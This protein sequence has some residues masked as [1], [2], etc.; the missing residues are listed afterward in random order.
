MTPSDLVPSFSTK[1]APS[2]V[3]SYLAR[4]AEAPQAA[5]ARTQ[6]ATLSMAE[7]DRA[8]SSVAAAISGVT[9][10]S[11]ND[12]VVGVFAYPGF[13]LLA[14]IWGALLSG[15]AYCPLSPDY[16]D[17]RL[18]DMIVQCNMSAIVC[19]SGLETKLREVAGTQVVI[20]TPDFQNET[21]IGRVWH[22]P[23]RPG[24]LAYVIFT[25]GSTGRPK[26]VMIEHRNIAQ[27]MSWFHESYDLGPGT[28]ILQKTPFSFDAA[29][30][31]LLSSAF[32]ATLIFGSQEGYRNPFEQVRLI[33]QFGVTMLQCVPT[34]WRALLETEQLETCTSLTRIFSGGEALP[35]ELAK[36]CLTA[37]PG[38]VLVNLYGPTECTINASAFAV[39]RE[40]LATE[41]QTVPIGTPVAGTAFT[42]LDETGAEV[43]G[44]AIGE[45]HIAGIQ[46][47]RGYLGHPSATEKSF[48]PHPAAPQH[49]SYRTGD[50]AKYN[51]DGSVQ[52][53]SRVDGQ[54][55]IRGYRIELDEIR[56]AIENHEWVK[57][58]AVFVE[59]A[60]TTGADVLVGCVELSPNQAQLMDAGAAREHHRSK[61][62][63]LQVK[64]QIAGLGVSTPEELADKI[65]LDLPGRHPT[66]H[67][68]DRAF[69]RKS[70]RHFEGSDPI[71]PDEMT[72]VL[73]SALSPRQ[74]Q[75]RPRQGLA[76]VGT[77]LRNF[78]QFS[79]PERLLP[80]Y[81]YASPGALYATQ[82]YLLA[83]SHVALAD[84]VY[85]YHPA[86]HVLYRMAPP[87]RGASPGLELQFVGKTR[88]IADV[89]K[90]NIR[91]VLDF[92]VGHILGVFDEVLPEFG[93]AIGAPSHIA[94]FLSDVGA[95]PDDHYLG[96][97]RLTTDD[98][99]VWQGPA[100]T[101]YVQ[102]I[103]NGVSGLKTGL[104]ALRDDGLS[105]LGPKSIERNH[106]IAINQQVFERSQVGVGLCTH[107]LE[108]PLA[109]VALGRA[110]QRLQMNDRR[111]GFMPSGYNSTTGH[112]LRAA[113]R[114]Y[115]LIGER[116]GAFYFC[117]GGRVS[118]AQVAHRGMKEDSV[119]S[120]GPLELIKEELRARLPDY[121]VPRHLFLVDEIPTSANGKLDKRAARA[122]IDLSSLNGEA[123][124][125]APQNGIEAEI[126]RRWA[127]IIG[128]DRICT[129]Q[130]FFDAG[131]DSLGAVK[132]VMAINEA[133]DV[134]LPLE[135]IFEAA[136]IEALAKLIKAEETVA[137]T[138]LVDLA[139]AVSARSSQ[140]PIP[141]SDL[142][143]FC[144]PGLGGYPMSLRSLA[145]ELAPTG[146]PVVGVRLMASTRMK[147][148]TLTS[149]Q[150]PNATSLPCGCANPRAPTRWS[151]IPSARG[152]PSRSPASW[153]PPASSS[154]T[155]S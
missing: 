38:A 92:E 116:K 152:L 52:F 104:Y 2:L 107:G 59:K 87:P 30:W 50:L 71:T 16:P 68:V 39:T 63:K 54:V 10:A 150:W 3:T 120:K 47:G 153:R 34:L 13:D 138:R 85:Y 114:F 22:K 64:A 97:F 112:D 148:L 151:A 62:S 70:Y 15:S 79:S 132:L 40:W 83:C 1:Q 49:R 129:A 82:I 102:P 29:Q 125:R 131:G 73:K 110:M 19:E 100:V 27:Q 133:F 66:E 111:L 78:G 26:G 109:Y 84:G 121:M 37:L 106:V 101:A 139:P 145:R 46:V 69:A 122:L 128:C 140:G 81:A 35:R 51:Y 5:V 115:D 45:L 130:S 60:P 144:W 154:T 23:V 99:D 58:A 43:T 136:T 123:Q 155:C 94:G 135:V 105:A 21:H 146:R 119:H 149:A 17:D 91:E 86:Q 126:A 41:Q 24:D 32:G 74:I 25:S 137:T 88:A 124:G 103:G 75:R 95:A 142:P 127:D 143:I 118:S 117:V 14:G 108:C 147:R 55:K 4:L 76:E 134:D 98:A 11:A 113:V 36:D 9:P 56:N 93:M 8:A 33:N 57:A 72:S 20:I 96:G 7:L 18:R 28:I 67:H 12:S 6:E 61:S 89:Y 141:Q 77:M 42:I 80:K 48:K 90:L 31:E 65:R 44:D 53:L